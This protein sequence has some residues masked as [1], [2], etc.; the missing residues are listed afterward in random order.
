M[1]FH[2]WTLSD[3]AV[4]YVVVNTLIKPRYILFFSL[5]VITDEGEPS[6]WQ[7]KASYVGN[8]SV[9]TDVLMYRK[10]TEN[11]DSWVA[12]ITYCC[13][14]FLVSIHLV[15]NSDYIY[16]MTLRS[17][18]SQEKWWWKCHEMISRKHIVKLPFRILA[19]SCQTQ[20]SMWTIG[21]FHWL[22]MIK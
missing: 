12:H 22:K 15:L 19:S 20:H 10:V 1:G 16:N 7:S 14:Y 21:N 3:L 4:Y 6:A 8:N 17:S 5:H 11:G 18:H 13:I 9:I 2:M